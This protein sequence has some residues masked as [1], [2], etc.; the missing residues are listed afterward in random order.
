MGKYVIFMLSGL[1]NAI[2][3][4][5]YDV[6]IVSSPPLFAGVIGKELSANIV[7]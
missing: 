3:I 7:I 5:N 2:K 4:K 6:L 1:I